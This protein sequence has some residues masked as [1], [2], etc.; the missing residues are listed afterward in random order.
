MSESD[1]A[2]FASSTGQQF[3]EIDH[4]DAHFEANRADYEELLRM[5]GFERGWHVLDAGCGGGNFLPWI[6]EIVGSEGAITAFDL[7]PENIE[8]TRRRVDA[9]RLPCPV[10]SVVGSVLDLP[11]ADNHVDGV[12][13]ANTTQYLTDDELDTA[14]AE[15]RRVTRPGGL[16]AVKE[17]D[18][19]LMRLRPSN[20]SYLWRAHE[21]G[22]SWNRFP[23]SWRGW[24]LRR[25]FERAG[26]EQTWAKSTLIERRAPLSSFQRESIANFVS[27]VFAPLHARLAEESG[28]PAEEIRFWADLRDNTADSILNH[29]DFYMSEGQVLAVGRVPVDG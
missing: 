7:A 21:R 18:M 14:L 5:V 17:I 13:C 6:A 8:L 2:L 4:L 26:L 25:L 22:Q 16:V 29:P 28:A 10:E 12:W 19:S 9:W 1:R 23:G 3:T 24:N 20:P 15:F 27:G 11:F